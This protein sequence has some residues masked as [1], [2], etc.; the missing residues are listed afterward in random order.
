LEHGLKP[1]GRQYVHLATTKELALRIGKRRDPEPVL[2]EI[3]ALRAHQDGI[4]FY[5]ANELI[6]LVDSLPPQY[7]S[8]PPLS[9]V[10]IERLAKEQ[11]K[12]TAISPFAVLDLGLQPFLP[13]ALRRKKDKLPDW[14][15]E[16]RRWR[17]REGKEPS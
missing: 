7:L 13:P 2:V 9:K 11:K 16:A 12:E 3:H 8:G 5:Q 17:R 10:K 6:F 4:L 14:K 1:I 15:R